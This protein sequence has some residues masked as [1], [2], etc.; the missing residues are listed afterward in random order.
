MATATETWLKKDGDKYIWTGGYE[1]KDMPKQAGFRWNPDERR[2]WTTFQDNAAKLAK[3]A[4]PAL[5]AELESYLEAKTQSLAGSRAAS[6]NVDLPVPEGLDYLPFQKAGIQYAVQR[7][8]VLFGD[9]MGLGKTIQAVGVINA[10]PDIRKV[11]VVSPASL[12]LNWKRELEKWLVRPLSVGI[13]NGDIPDVDVVIVSYDILGKHKA[14]L[15]NRK[16]DLLVADEAHYI[17]NPKAQRTQHLVGSEKKDKSL[18]K[19]VHVPGISDQAERKAFLTGTPM[20]NRP[21]EL[22]PIVSTLAPETFPNF[23]GFAK[24]YAGA[25]EG[26]YG[27]DFSGATHLDELQDKLRSTV[28]VRRLKKDVLTELPAKRRQVIELE[29]TGEAKKQLAAESALAAN[30][31]GNLEQLRAAVEL[32]KASESDD[33]YNAAVAKLRDAAQV[34]FEEISRQ[35]H[36]V[37]LSKVPFVVEHVKNVLDHESKVIVFAHHR[38]VIDAIMAAFP[39]EAVKLT[40]EDSTEGRQKAVDDF[41]NNPDVK[42][43]VGS[44][45]AAGV[46]ITLTASSHVVFAELDWVPGNV[47]QAEDRA[48][49]IGQQDS[50]L[51]QHLVFDESLDAKMAKTLVEKQEIIDKALDT[52][53]PPV[54]PIEEPTTKATSRAALAA[55]PDIPEAE[56]TEIHEQLRYLASVCDG[57]LEQDRAGF[58]KVDTHIG[59]SLAAAPHLTQKQARLGRILVRKYH[60]QLESAGLLST[61][62]EEDEGTTPEMKQTAPVTNETA[63]DEAADIP[64]SEPSDEQEAQV[65]QEPF[66]VTISGVRD[67][68]RQ[69]PRHIAH[70]TEK[71]KFLIAFPYDAHL[72]AA[73]KSIPGVR[74]NRDTKNWDLSGAVADTPAV[75]AMLRFAEQN[76]FALSVGTRDRVR[77][78]VEAAGGTLVADT[79]TGDAEPDTGE[80]GEDANKLFRVSIGEGYGGHPFSP[81]QILRWNRPYPPEISDQLVEVVSATERYY[82]ED[83]MSFGVGD[84]RGY[85]YSASVRITEPE[86][87]KEIIAAEKATK[88]RRQL[89]TVLVNLRDTIRTKGSRPSDAQPEGDRLFDT[90]TIYGGGDWFVVG[91][92]GIWYVR[93][94]GADGDDWSQNN[95]HTGGAGAIG[96]VVDSD[97]ALEARLRNL[98]TAL[99]SLKAGAPLPDAELD[100]LTTGLPD[101]SF[102]P[103][104]TSETTPL[105][106]KFREVHEQRSDESRMQDELLSNKNTV[107]PDDEAGT[108]VWLDDPG[109]AD[110]AGVDTPKE[111]KHTAHKKKKA[112]RG[113]APTGLRGVKH[114]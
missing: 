107:E 79:P 94:N 25:Y 69:H 95:V 81:G 75:E 41:Q 19:Y 10:T 46:G 85:V 74:F 50:V 59:K 39:S 92:E 54:T 113:T 70:N 56:I 26:R 103:P 49:R 84:E 45:K 63:P 65:D 2:W 73:V 104:P 55:L 71:S 3:W 33:E 22:W 114:N 83:G 60:G 97:P 93:N 53:P 72:V 38:D 8:N 21:I 36:A 16:W 13:A 1:T 106:D 62:S 64:K 102:T 111:P 58:N 105:L 61:T 27:W 77:E 98:A 96:W 37:A 4:N 14:A 6:S 57:A 99:E 68:W 17:K 35:R 76:K 89:G 90:Q 82:R 34:A 101:A 20:L 15:M 24:R 110:I 32:A 91:Q 100:E 51:I 28:M 112:R 87:G 67:D 40:G 78:I 48:H 23:M 18:G 11:L 109:R 47:T 52:E 30:H 86:K 12:K 43:F 5:R 44:I 88:Q 7:D 29:P 9:E 108:A 66:S 80:G 42:L 31:E